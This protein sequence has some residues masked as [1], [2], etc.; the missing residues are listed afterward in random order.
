MYDVAI[1]GGG[2]A[3]LAAAINAAS[4]GLSTVVLCD[5]P[6]GQAGTSSLIENLMGFPTGISGPDLTAH[7]KLQAEKFGAV[8]EDCVCAELEEVGGVYRLTTKTGKRV[9]ARSVICATGARYRKL[10]DRTGASAFEGRGV[11]YSAT[12]EEVTR[13]CRCKEVV[14][15]G[16]ANSAGQAAM[17]LSEHAERVHLVVR[18]PSILDTMSS[19]LMERIYDCPN[20]TLHFSTEVYEISGGEWVERVVLA[21]GDELVGLDV[22]DV[23]VMIGAE[24]NVPFLSGVCEVDPQGFVKT[25]DFFQ[26]KQ[27][28]LFAVGD[29]RSGSVKRVANAVGEGSS[30]IKW[31]WRFLFPPP[32]ALA[33]A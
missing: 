17:Y 27:P 7:A 10:A 31:V 13:H 23:Y 26:T 12:P 33:Q 32:P 3:G 15:V 20:I 5:Q 29:I 25:D 6:G 24:P 19:Y 18:K 30:V 16:G 1:I 14:V 28:G 8:F 11:H 21:K 9:L 4:E 2:P 22:S